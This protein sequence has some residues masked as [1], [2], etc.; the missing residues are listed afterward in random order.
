[1]AGDFAQVLEGR[2]AAL[3]RATG[4]GGLKR[5]LEQEL[6]DSSRYT[7]EGPDIALHSDWAFALSLLLHELASNAQHHGSL[8]TPEGRVD[9]CWHIEDGD[10]VLSW[11][12][13]GGVPARRPVSPGVGHLLVSY[14]AVKLKGC[15]NILYL[16]AGLRCDIR[17]SLLARWPQR[18]GAVFL[19]SRERGERPAHAI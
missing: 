12:E 14:A 7:L 2:V 19:G 18:R 16:N 11:Q 10:L 9:V 15:A 6:G 13:S 3:H 17:I 8:S 1:V 5:V 4:G